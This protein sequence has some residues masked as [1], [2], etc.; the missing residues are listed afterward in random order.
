MVSHIHIAI[1]LSFEKYQ[2]GRL[3]RSKCID[4][5]EVKSFEVDSSHMLLSSEVKSSRMW[6]SRRRSTW[7]RF[8]PKVGSCFCTAAT[9]RSTGRAYNILFM[10]L[11]LLCQNHFC[12]ANSVLDLFISRCGNWQTVTGFPL[13][14]AAINIDLVDNS[15]FCFEQQPPQQ[16]RSF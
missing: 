11:L 15:C 2:I 6:P 5:F 9:R 8:Q 1:F 4:I 7:G 16:P 10:L 12:A 14:L 13:F 3:A